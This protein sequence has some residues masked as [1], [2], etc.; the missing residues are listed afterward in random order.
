MADKKS[1]DRGASE[2]DEV[3]ND[4]FD[5]AAGIGEKADISEADDPNKVPAGSEQPPVVEDKAPEKPE[6]KPPEQPAQQPGESDEK[7]EQRYKTLQGIHRKD[8]EIWEAKQAE[9]LAQIEE[10][11]KPEKPAQE[12]PTAV[13]QDLYDSL[14]DEEKAALKE[15]DEDFDVVSKME[16]KKRDIALNKLR[17][18][19]DAFKKDV[20]ERLTPTATYVQERVEK[21]AEVEKEEHFGSIRKAHPDFE[22]YR[23]EGAIAEW[24]KTKPKYLQVG[25]M[26]AYT[27]GEAED[28]IDLIATFKR[29]N[30]ITPSE[31]ELDNVVQM[32]KKKAEKKQAMTAVTTKRGAVNASMSVASDYDGSWDEAISKQG[33]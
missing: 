2:V 17:A 5:T 6:E 21:E 8:K 18:E 14:T 22:K 11:K 1:D 15:Y 10:L 32:D 16:G 25:M 7:Y 20:L 24:I 30:N 29:E 3:F 33:G 9:L 4:S 27:Q 19:I 28:V 31:P 26:H 13:S 12:K 23:D